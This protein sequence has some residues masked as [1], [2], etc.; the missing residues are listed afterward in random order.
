MNVAN[1]LMAE[2][3]ADPAALVVLRQMMQG[4]MSDP[5]SELYARIVRAAQAHPAKVGVSGAPGLA[6][7]YGASGEYDP[8]Q[9]QIRYDPKFSPP[10][11]QGI[12]GHELLHFLMQQ[13][14]KNTPEEQHGLMKDLFGSDRFQDEQTLRNTPVGD[15]E[16]FQSIFEPKAGPAQ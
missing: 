4:D 14:L 10:E 12:L 3:F 11:Q 9:S 15:T 8:A 5:R 7:V 2:I 16:K 6:N 1:I 13:G